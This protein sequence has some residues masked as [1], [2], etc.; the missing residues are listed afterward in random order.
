MSH[1][2]S[3]GPTS[4]AT[5]SIWRAA[6]RP[7]AYPLPALAR[8]HQSPRFGPDMIGMRSR[9]TTGFVNCF[10]TGGK[11]MLGSSE[12]GANYDED[13]ALVR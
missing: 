12:G 4:D 9:P 1:T 6:R 8:L 7:V 3:P 13:H 10:T 5:S 2:T 11:R